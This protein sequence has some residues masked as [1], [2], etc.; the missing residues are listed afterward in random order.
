M[1]ELLRYDA[2]AQ[3]FFRRAL[4]DCDVNGFA[5]R[6]RDNIILLVGAANR[7]PDIFDDPD[8]LDVGRAANP[9]LT[10]GRGIHYCLGAPLARLEGRIVFETLLERFP[11]IELLGDRPRFRSGVVLRGLQ[12]LPLRCRRARARNVP[13]SAACARSIFERPVPR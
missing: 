5:L 12:S 2:P 13:R 4:T 9:H 10:L 6:E 11:E 3:A 7:D 8:R 1:E